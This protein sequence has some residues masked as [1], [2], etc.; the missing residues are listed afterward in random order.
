M[1]RRDGASKQL[2]RTRKQRKRRGIEKEKRRA[3]RSDA[4]VRKY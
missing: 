3:A 1:P 4:A 2:S